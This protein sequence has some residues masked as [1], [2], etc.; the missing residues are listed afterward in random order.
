MENKKDQTDII[1]PSSFRIDKCLVSDIHNFNEQIN[2]DDHLIRN[3]I[4]SVA[5]DYEHSLFGYGSLDPAVFAR[6][7]QYDPSYLRRRVEHPYQLRE[8]SSEDVARYRERVAKSRA[9]G[10]VGDDR[11]WDT[12][13]EDAMYILS[14]KP[15]NFDSYGEFVTDKD[16]RQ[17]RTK[18]HASFTLFTAIRAV[19][20]GRGKTVY[21]YTLN[22]NFE[23]NLTQ[24][25]IRGER[26]SLLTLRRRELDSLYLYLTNLKIN[27]ALDRRSRSTMGDSCADFSLL[28]SIAA[29]PAETR[30]GRPVEAKRRKQLLMDAVEQVN[31][32]TELSVELSWTKADGARAAY[33]PIFYFGE[34]HLHDYENIG[35][36][37]MI[38]HTERYAIQ[39]QVIQ[40]EFLSMFKKMF[41]SGYTPVDEKAFLAWVCDNKKNVPEKVTALKNAYIT[42]YR[43]VP[44]NADALNNAVFAALGRARGNAAEALKKVDL[45]PVLPGKAKGDAKEDGLLF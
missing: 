45:K 3:I 22:E 37:R 30:D 38:L 10:E 29:I 31:E 18:T 24:Y 9:D 34:S 5:E 28:C 35:R 2:A 33:V 41:V 43:C 42:L 1:S 16:G 6:R 19:P 11:I 21:A 13:L 8:M 36:G 7:W 20:C 23:K 14:N 4:Y 17:R 32:N 26:Q 39:R 27:L 40:H 44:E 12:R 25:Y 15:F